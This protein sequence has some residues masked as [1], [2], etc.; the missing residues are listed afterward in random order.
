MN[1]ESKCE[2]DIDEQET[3]VAEHMCPLCLSDRVAGLEA[4][5]ADI[6]GLIPVWKEGDFNLPDYVRGKMDG[7]H[8]CADELQAILNKEQIGHE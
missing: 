3:A 4:K 5:L 6:A 7:R 2:H 1:R 8:E